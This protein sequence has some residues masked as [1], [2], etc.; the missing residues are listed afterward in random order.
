MFVRY[1][2]PPCGRDRADIGGSALGAARRGVA[3]GV[4]GRIGGLLGRRGGGLRMGGNAGA[5]CQ[6]RG[7]HKQLRNGLHRTRP[8]SMTT[9]FYKELSGVANGNR[10]RAPRGMRG[11][12]RKIQG[13]TE[14]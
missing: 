2:A 11:S 3:R 10:S 9:V 8:I 5:A 6:K 4:G 7:N 14:T 12:L 13:I 1:L